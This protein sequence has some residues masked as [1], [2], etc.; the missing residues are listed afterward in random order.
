MKNKILSLGDD[1]ERLLRE[2]YVG[3]GIAIGKTAEGNSFVGYILTGRNSSSQARELEWD[4]SRVIRTKGTEQAKLKQGN[5]ELLIYPAVVSVGNR[6]VASNGVQ[7]DLLVDEA[8]RERPIDVLINAMKFRTFRNGIDIT[9]YEPDSPHFTPRICACLDDSLGGFYIVSKGG[10]QHPEIGSFSFGLEQGVARAIF[11][12]RGGNENPLL[13]FTGSP[14][15]FG[16][17]FR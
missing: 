10:G 11:T 15:E 4:G 1:F 13:S 3:R 8:M 16:G 5:P 9:A 14:L 7:T 6:I 2:G 12:Y 17:P